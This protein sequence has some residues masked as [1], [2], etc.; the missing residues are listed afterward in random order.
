MHVRP[1]LSTCWMLL[2]LQ[3]IWALVIPGLLQKPQVYSGGNKKLSLRA[4]RMNLS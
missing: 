1:M 3:L 2:E 4:K